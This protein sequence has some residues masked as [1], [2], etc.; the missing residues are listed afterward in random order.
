MTSMRTLLIVVLVAA[1]GLV[2]LAVWQD[3]TSS[4]Q[5][6]APAYSEGDMITVE[7]CLT[8]A[9][10]A[11]AFAITPADRDGLTSAMTSRSEALTYSYE[12]VGRADELRP[13]AGQ[14]V[15]IRG[16]V[17]D[18]ETDAE[19]DTTQKTPPAGQ[20]SDADAQVKTTTEAQIEV[21]RLN[22]ES[23]EATNQSCPTAQE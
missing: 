4:R 13:Y 22:V 15:R 2:G 7:G 21:R 17:S 18:P 8:A 5:V 23:V 14:V 3:R 9:R 19:I 11:T 1:A 6:E 12:L 20:T 10:G 16:R